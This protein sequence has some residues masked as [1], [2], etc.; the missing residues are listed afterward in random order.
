MR[1]KAI[2][3]LRTF[4]VEEKQA[5]TAALHRLIALN[6]DLEDEAKKHW[7][8]Q[9]HRAKRKTSTPWIKEMLDGGLSQ[10]NRDC[11]GFVIFQSGCYKGNDD[12][13]AW[14]RF[15]DYFVRTGELILQEW[16]SGSLI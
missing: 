8:R 1:N 4:D 13:I 14:Q 9:A 15:Q 6:K 10:D 2:S 12:K 3:L 11:L 5:R 16:H 7:Q